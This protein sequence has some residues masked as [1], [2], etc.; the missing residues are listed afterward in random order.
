MTT[1][2]HCNDSNSVTLPSFNNGPPHI[3]KRVFYQMIIIPMRQSLSSPLSAHCKS[4]PNATSWCD[5]TIALSQLKSSP[6]YTTLQNHASMKER[7]PWKWH[8]PNTQRKLK[9][10]TM[11]KG[12]G[13]RIQGREVHV[14]SFR[15]CCLKL[16]TLSGSYDVKESSKMITTDKLVSLQSGKL[17]PNVSQDWQQVLGGVKHCEWSCRPLR[18]IRTCRS[19][20][21]DCIYVGI[22][23]LRPP[24]HATVSERGPMGRRDCCHCRLCTPARTSIIRNNGRTGPLN[25]CPELLRPPTCA[26]QSGGQERSYTELS[27]EGT[28]GEKGG[29]ANLISV[30]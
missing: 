20:R 4:D 9:R 7:N 17:T 11:N 18:D 12:T 27:E 23:L 15:S 6:H 1:R 25:N 21:L 14:A 10:H 13:P 16:P 2:V 5:L 8:Y 19:A 3:Q 26:T 30:M 29:K 28:L 24:M 22:V